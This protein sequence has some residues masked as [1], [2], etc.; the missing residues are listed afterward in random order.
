MKK[1]RFRS[2]ILCS[3]CLAAGV[4]LGSFPLWQ[5]GEYS[6]PY[7]MPSPP[8]DATFGRREI[9]IEGG[10]VW[11]RRSALSGPV[12]WASR[13]EFTVIVKKHQPERPVTVLNALPPEAYLSLPPGVAAT[14]QGAL[15]LN[16]PGTYHFRP[17]AREK[18]SFLVMG[19]PRAQPQNFE[20]GLKLGEDPLFALCLGDLVFKGDPLEY[21][22]VAGIVAASPIPVYFTVGNHDIEKGGRRNYLR[23]FGEAN[24]TFS[25]GRDLFAMLD[26]SADY[27]YLGD[28][29]ISWLNEVLDKP[30]TRH[31]FV[32]FHKPPHDPRPGQAYRIKYR[33]LRWRLQ[34][35]LERHGIPLA[36]AAHIH[37]YVEG[38]KNG[39]RYVITGGLNP[40]PDARFASHVVE[41]NVDKDSVSWKLLFLD[42]GK[43]AQHR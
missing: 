28:R 1:L 35:T 4:A 41:V 42:S 19:D 38:E 29:R 13:P 2:L 30:G 10:V 32:S 40:L 43:S 17:R 24:Y 14:G 22:E 31:R 21:A 25:L 27:P 20:A 11:E 8:T 15:L 23:F 37:D 7:S 6:H 5:Y 3:A 33:L 18:Y 26:T 34:R 16:Q 9:T 12:L 39:V 36:F